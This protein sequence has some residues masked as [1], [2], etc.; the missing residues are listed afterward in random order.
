MDFSIPAHPDLF[1]SHPEDAPAMRLLPC[2]SRHQPHIQRRKAPYEC[3]RPYAGDHRLGQLPLAA[4]PL[5]RQ[6]DDVEG[7]AAGRLGAAILRLLEQ[8]S[9]GC[10]TPRSLLFGKAGSTESAPILLAWFA[11]LSA[12]STARWAF[13]LLSGYDSTAFRSSRGASHKADR[14]G[15]VYTGGSFA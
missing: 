15:A 12:P 5:R 10:R 4:P 2:G 14:S 3:C 1:S 11:D 7:L 9:S 8:P 13:L 6:Y